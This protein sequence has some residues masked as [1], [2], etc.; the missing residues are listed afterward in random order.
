MQV[1]AGRPGASPRSFTPA[2][3]KARPPPAPAIKRPGGPRRRACFPGST[4]ARRR[5]QACAQLRAVSGGRAAGGRGRGSAWVRV[6]GQGL[7]R[8]RG[9]GRGRTGSGAAARSSWRAVPAG[10]TPGTMAWVWALVLL[11]VLGSARAER[12]CRVSS[13]RVKENFDKARVGIGRAAPWPRSPVPRVLPPRRPGVHAVSPN[14]A[15]ASFAVRRDLV[16]HGQEGPRGPLSA[17]Q[18]HRPVLRG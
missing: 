1:L 9:R 14:P 18:H 8:G 17:G 5:G 15:L 11:A 3:T 10:R 13:F 6:Q 16:R 2:V 12:D 4:R 7:G